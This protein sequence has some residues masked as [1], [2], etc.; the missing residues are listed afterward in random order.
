MKIPF[1]E[2]KHPLVH[3]QNGRTETIWWEDSDGDIHYLDD[4]PASSPRWMIG[5]FDSVREAMERFDK[6]TK[7]EEWD[8]IE[9]HLDDLDE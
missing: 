9:E 3:M 6:M 5:S 2:I 4:N 1:T 8:V 7:D